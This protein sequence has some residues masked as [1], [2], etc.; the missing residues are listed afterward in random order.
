MGQEPGGNVSSDQPD[1]D[2]ELDCLQERLPHRVAQVMRK[3]RSPSA[4]PY[5]IP[6]GVALTAG[7]F[8]GFLP[9]LGFWM[10]PLGLVVLAQDVPA[11]RPPLA[12][13][14]AWINRKRTG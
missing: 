5:R 9:I 6:I 14:T 10:T 3:V 1:L 4:K 7:G 8:L 13:L 2:E 12:R 11:M